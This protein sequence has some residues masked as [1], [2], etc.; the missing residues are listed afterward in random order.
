M[1]PDTAEVPAG[2][3]P[4]ERVEAGPV[5]VRRLRASDA[6][7]IAAAV[8]ASLDYLQ[9]WMP[10][11]TPAA[12]DRG[13]QLARVAEADQ[14][15]EAGLSYTYSVLTAETGTLVGEVALHRRMGDS[16]AEIGYWI[17]AGQAGRGYGTSASAALT[18]VALGLSGVNRVEIH[19]DAANVGSAAVARRLGYRLDR[20]EERRPEAPGESGRLMVWVLDRP[21]PA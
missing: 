14:R 12:A 2:E 16:T 7:A 21:D 19:C 20:I 1:S 15:W 9:P 5:V 4:P 6:S 11:A 3:A 8:G 10:W 13:N 18:T 17:A